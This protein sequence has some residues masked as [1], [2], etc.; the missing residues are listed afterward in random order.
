MVCEYPICSSQRRVHLLA[1]ANLRGQQI[2]LPE[3]NIKSLLGVS[4][5]LCLMPEILDLQAGSTDDKSMSCVVRITTT[6]Y[7]RFLPS[8][9]GRSDALDSAIRCLALAMESFYLTR[10]QAAVAPS[11]KGTLFIYYNQAIKKLHQALE[12]PEESISSET[13]CATALLGSVEVRL[14]SA[15]EA[16]GH[17]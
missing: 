4:K 17:G 7:V 2:Q 13:L 10:R 8:I 16:N 14:L 3:S 6:F 1:P 5:L 12:D 9:A 15:T 11:N